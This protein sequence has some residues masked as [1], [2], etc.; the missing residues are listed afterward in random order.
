MSVSQARIEA[1]PTRRARGA[2]RGPGLGVLGSLALLVAWQAGVGWGHL[3][4]GTVPTP[5]GILTQMT[6]DGPAL[7]GLN[8]L[9]TLRSAALGWVWGNG[10]GIVLAVLAT[11][12]PALSGLVLRLGVVSFCLPVVAI[13]PVLAIVFSGDVPRIVLAALSVFFTTQVAATIGL[14]SADTA[15][16]DVVHAFGGRPIHRFTKVRLRAALPS[17]FAG[18]R[19]AAPAAILGSIVGELLGAENGLGVLLINAQQSLNYGRTW[20]VILVATLVA[21]CGYGLTSLLARLVTPWAR[22]TRANLAVGLDITAGGGCRNGVLRLLRGVAGTVGFVLLALLAWWGL[23]RL[24]GVSPFIGK[25]P[26]DVWVYLTDPATGAENRAAIVGEAWVSLRDGTIGLLAGTAAAVVAAAAFTVWP[27][28]RQVF[29]GPAMALQSMPLIA[30]T[31]V[32]V[33][34]FGRSLTA[35][36]VI[37]GI[38]AFFPTLV[39]VTL[40]LERTP[41]GVLDLARVYAGSPLAILLKIRLPLA[42]PSLFASLRVAAPLAV[43]G[44][45]LAEWLA[46]GQGLGYAILQAT[47]TSDYDGLWARVVVVTA[48]SLLLYWVIGLAERIVLGRFAPVAPR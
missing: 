38:I 30:I 31:P 6:A 22:E 21:G 47:S 34:I 11:V 18:L 7:Y 28:L 35:V 17:L 13:G 44:A 3:G 27:A 25:G 46:T 8:A 41:H 4:N 9:H 42:L 32:I 26:L 5:W 20:G 19:V 24:S 37:G 14:R 15:A 16:L 2:T 1:A 36:A 10:L 45:L 43:T 39:N 12:V 33:L 40:A 29:I 48:F 23:L